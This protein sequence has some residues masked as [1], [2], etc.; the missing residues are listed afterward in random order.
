[1]V[2]AGKTAFFGQIPCH[3]RPFPLECPWLV[4]FVP[5]RI[6]EKGT[7]ATTS[8]SGLGFLSGPDCWPPKRIHLDTATLRLFTD[9]PSRTPVEY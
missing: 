6:K 7:I 2:Q 3:R 8:L 4:M 1:M 9:S 5:L